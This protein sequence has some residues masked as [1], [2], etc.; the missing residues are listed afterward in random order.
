MSTTASTTPSP[1]ISAAPTTLDLEQADLADAAPEATLIATDLANPTITTPQDVP[2]LA[3]RLILAANPNTPNRW[4]HL[5]V[6]FS[7]FFALISMMWL[8]SM[9]YTMAIARALEFRV[10]DAPVSTIL[11]VSLLLAFGKFWMKLPKMRADGVWKASRTKLW[12]C[13]FMAGAMHMLWIYALLASLPMET[14]VKARAISGVDLALVY[15][16]YLYLFFRD[17]AAQTIVLLLLVCVAALAKEFLR[18]GM[19]EGA[20]KDS[21]GTSAGYFLLLITVH[22]MVTQNRPK[23][24]LH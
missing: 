1:P 21:L 6:V 14:S 20:H 3:E 24:S 17:I 11:W 19:E 7:L 9:F 13:V 4:A 12:V 16:L 15:I 18:R 10:D 23:R 2:E 22:W 5:R 8:T